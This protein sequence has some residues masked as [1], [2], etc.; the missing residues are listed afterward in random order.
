M[1]FNLTEDR[2]MLSDTLTR[3]LADHY[4]IERRNTVAYGAPYHDPALWDQLSELGTLYALVPESAGGMGG[5]GFDIAVVF[6]ALGRA[7]CPEPMLGATM[8]ARLLMAADADVATLLRGERRYAVAISEIDAPYDLDD[9]ATVA[10]TDGTTATLTG[11]KSTVY[12]GQCADAFLVAARHAE[13]VGVFAVKAEDA[14]VTGYGMLDGAGAAEVLLEDTPASV[15]LMNGRPALEDMLNAGVVALCAEAVGAMD[16]TYAI[17]VDYLKQRKQFGVPIGKFQV[18]QHRAVDMLTEIEQARSITI[19]AAA[20]LGGADAARYASMAKNMIGRVAR[21]VAE[22]SIQMHGGIAMTWDYA[23]SHYAK[24]LVM[25][26]S[27]LG[28]TD[29][30]L[31]QV[32]KSYVA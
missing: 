4:P 24:R 16:V 13:S 21:L 9:I 14:K 29:H 22:E 15:V 8:A 18:L 1:D 20:E 17:T 2:Q 28:D 25:L 3:F 26:D 23:I 11:R 7:L 32:M 30:H 6:E 27:Q 5:S 19:K 31:S 12:G 10:V